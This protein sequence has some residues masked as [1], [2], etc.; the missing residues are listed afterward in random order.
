MYKTPIGSR[1]IAASSK[2]S[3][4]HLPNVIPKV[5]KGILYQVENFQRKI[6]FY[7][8]FIKFWVIEN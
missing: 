1:F 8:H 7:P 2:C 5:L 6:I 4:K 3:P